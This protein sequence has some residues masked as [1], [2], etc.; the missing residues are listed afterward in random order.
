MSVS[1]SG[2]RIDLGTIGAVAG[3]LVAALIALL[4]LYLAHILLRTMPIVVALASVLYLLTERNATTDEPLTLP[5]TSVFA[6]PS[7]VFLGSG[8]LIALS[9]LTGGR[10]PAFY[11]IAAALSVLVFVQ[12]AFAADR[13]LHVGIVLV[14]VLALGFVV[15]FAGLLGSAGYIGVDIWIH[16][17]Q[18]VEG[19]LATNSLDGMGTTKYVAAPLYHLLV[20]ATALL[21][22]LST[23]FALYASIGVAMPLSV[24]FVY[25]TAGRFV[26][27]RWAAFAAMAYT[28]SDFV[29][30][31]SVHLIP[32]SLGLMIFLAILFLFVR[33]QR[34]GATWSEIPLM[35]LL[36]IAMALTHQVASFIMLVLLFSGVI[37]QL[38]LTLESVRQRLLSGSY[39]G[40]S[41][42]NV[43]GYFAFALGVLVLDWGLTPWGDRTF[44]E[45]VLEILRGSV[46]ESGLFDRDGGGGTTTAVDEG[47][48][49]ETVIPLIDYTGFLLLVSGAVLGSLYVLQRERTSQAAVTLIVATAVMAAFTLVPPLFGLRNLLPGRWFAFLYAVMV[50]LT[51]VGF[52][53]LRRVA[54]PRVFVIVV[55]AFAVA[56]SGGMVFAT[57]ATQDAPAFPDETVRYSYTPTEMTAAATVTEITTGEVR[58]D[59]P[60]IAALNAHGDTGRFAVAV[61][62]EDGRPEYGTLLYREYQTTGTPLFLDEDGE[63]H[64]EQV[65][66]EEMCEGRDVA[67]TNGDVT[68]CTE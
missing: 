10:G 39:G 15:R 48:L 19:I 27:P 9:I 24:L 53:R 40:S 47:L 18:Y 41:I 45:A 66:A 49:A 3:L 12:I 23:R 58:T 31:W 30:V 46:A 63:R 55:L 54:T 5:R 20:A 1:I 16:I 33:I 62:P 65:T 32:T 2:G 22:D 34:R 51:V 67:Y 26:T 37:A 21:A 6:L 42:R 50:L 13:D 35:V 38:L 7:V 60:Y 25:V 56:F 36:V 28:I 4:N 59:T 8:A 44:T 29:V 61:V 64:T 57:N 17:P 52:D 43:H 11:T 14:Q 68:L